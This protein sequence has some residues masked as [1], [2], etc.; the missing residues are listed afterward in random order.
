MN[1]AQFG[2]LK[3]LAE[4]PRSHLPIHTFI[5]SPPQPQHPQSTS[6]ISLIS[7]W[8]NLIYM[9]DVQHLLQLAVTGAKR[10]VVAVSG[11]EVL[12]VA[13]VTEVAVSSESRD[14]QYITWSLIHHLS[15]SNST[16]CI[17]FRLSRFLCIS[18]RSPDFVSLIVSQFHAWNMSKMSYTRRWRVENDITW[19]PIP[20]RDSIYLSSR[21]VTHPTTHTS[22]L[23]LGL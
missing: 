8:K 23:S 6:L 3:N 7:P 19:L 22:C 21:D 15:H 14:H 11:A 5:S 2:I 18:K 9:H 10:M 13:H 20:S 1:F 12:S 16:L 4:L 17:F